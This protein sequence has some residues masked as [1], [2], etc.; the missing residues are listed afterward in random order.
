MH[1][2][3]IHKRDT[4]DS[5]IQRR[6]RPMRY[7]KEIVPRDQRMVELH[8][9]IRDIPASSLF[10]SPVVKLA[11]LDLA[12]SHMVAFRQ[13]LVPF[14]PFFQKHHPREQVLLA[15]S[16]LRHLLQATELL[17]RH[18]VHFIDYDGIGFH[19]NNTPYIHGFVHRPVQSVFLSFE[20]HLL[21]YA[22]NHHISSFSTN[23]LVSACRHYLNVNRIPVNDAV[24]D[25]CVAAFS[26]LVNR[27]LDEVERYA[28]S[29]SKK[30]YVY[31]LGR[32][33]S[34]L[35]ATIE[36]A[37]IPDELVSLLNQCTEMVPDKRPSMVE[38]MDR[39]G[40]F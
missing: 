40:R 24:V 31:G 39:L 8:R 18:D 11:P 5:N 20:L 9:R 26:P 33:Y 25:E 7:T 19:A 14:F 34:F 29:Q 27:S 22:A 13:D 36:T 23:N 15:V 32:L 2:G 21:E 10:F 12:S 17:S 3:S 30:S 28:L 4:Y 1:P 35:L 6:D 38:A 16:S 37:D